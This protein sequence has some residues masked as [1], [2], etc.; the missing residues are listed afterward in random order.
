METLQQECEGLI[1][2]QKSV[3]ERERHEIISRE[4]DEKKKL[5]QEN[6]RLHDDKRNEASTFQ[7]ILEQQEGL[8]IYI[9]IHMHTYTHTYIYIYIHR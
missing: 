7:E 4:H 9:Y 6:K 1:R 2:E 8:Y 5:I 3:A